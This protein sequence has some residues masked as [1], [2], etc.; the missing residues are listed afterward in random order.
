MILI[1]LFN[2]KLLIK[3]KAKSIK[4]ILV[5]GYMVEDV[6]ENGKNV[7]QVGPCTS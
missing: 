6:V 1:Y 3:I 7:H 5:K 2:N 4:L